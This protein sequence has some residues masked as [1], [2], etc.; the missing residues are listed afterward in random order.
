MDTAAE[1]YELSVG[2][3]GVHAHKRSSNE[4]SVHQSACVAFMRINISQVS[5]ELVGYPS[6][7]TSQS[8]RCCFDFVTVVLRPSSFV[9][10][11]S[12]FVLRPSSSF[13]L[14][15]SS[16]V[17]LRPSSSFVVRRSS[18]VAVG[19]AVSAAVSA[20]A[21]SAAASAS[22]VAV[23]ALLLQLLLLQVLIAD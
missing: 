3:L 6:A 14:R 11:P 9:L 5:G 7:L 19:A 22:A 20:A 1:F 8:R 12:S 4:G 10:R 21:V 23:L 16:F 17:V 18:F 13:V 15:P 2:C